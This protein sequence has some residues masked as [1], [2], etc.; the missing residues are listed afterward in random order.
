MVMY[1]AASVCSAYL[2]TSETG[3]HNHLPRPAQ[4]LSQ[5]LGPIQSRSAQPRI[6][7]HNLAP[8]KV[9]TGQVGRRAGRVTQL[10]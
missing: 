9:A 10:N 6:R 5:R 4:A 3:E 8:A 1:Q 7:V 2:V